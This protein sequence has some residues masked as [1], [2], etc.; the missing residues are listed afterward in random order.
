MTVPPAFPVHMTA[1]QLRELGVATYGGQN[2]K[3]HM[4]SDI[5]VSERTIARWADG[6]YP[7]S[8]RMANLI[9]LTLENKA[10]GGSRF[11]SA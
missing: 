10:K 2:W 8:E 1:Q 11:Y 9:R 4:A 3:T 6:E 7:I 5:G